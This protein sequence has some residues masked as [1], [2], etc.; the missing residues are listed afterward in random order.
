[1]V[2][3]LFDITMKSSIKSSAVEMTYVD[4]TWTWGRNQC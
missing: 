4:Q 3:E 1:M 2:H